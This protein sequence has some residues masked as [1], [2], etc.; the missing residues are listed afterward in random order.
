M[1]R[2][3]TVVVGMMVGEEMTEA[4]GMTILI[5]VSL[6]GV[7]CAGPLRDESKLGVENE[8]SSLPYEHPVTLIL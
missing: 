5:Q 3:R 4:A 2:Q 7:V 8:P 1:D 6:L